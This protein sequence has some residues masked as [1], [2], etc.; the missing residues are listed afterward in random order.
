MANGGLG[1]PHLTEGLNAAHNLGY[2]MI[3]NQIPEISITNHV[4]SSV[5]DNPKEENICCGPWMLARKPSRKRFDS[6]KSGYYK[7]E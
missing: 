6:R 1:E 2:V 4:G 7:E 3:G 5:M